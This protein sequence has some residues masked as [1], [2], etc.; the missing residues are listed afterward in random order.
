MIQCGRVESG[1]VILVMAFGVAGCHETTE[2][3]RVKAENANLMRRVEADEAKMAGLYKQ[4]DELKFAVDEVRS[5]LTDLEL[6]KV[7]SEA[8][9]R[10]EADAKRVTAIK[11]AISECVKQVRASPNQGAFNLVLP[12][13]DAHY[14]PVTRQI[15]DKFTYKQQQ[16]ARYAFKKCM[17]ERG[18]VVT[19]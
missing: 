3:D 6:A 13:F 18:I 16:P 1:A 15:Q 5:G 19:K 12:A 11:L 8:N 4:I 2:I 14:N 17:A 9:G 7:R 10:S